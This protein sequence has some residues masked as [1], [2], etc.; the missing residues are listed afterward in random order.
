ML[1]Q[2]STITQKKLCLTLSVC[3]L[4][5]LSLPFKADANCNEPMPPIWVAEA[6]MSKLMRTIPDSKRCLYVSNSD[7]AIHLTG[8]FDT[9]TGA[10][11]AKVLEELP[12][13]RWPRDILSEKE[14]EVA[15]GIVLDELVA[16]QQM[17]N[18]I[19]G[20]CRLSP[21]QEARIRNEAAPYAIAGYINPMVVMDSSYRVVS[22][23][24]NGCERMMML[25]EY[26]HHQFASMGRTDE[27][28]IRYDLE[29]EKQSK[30]R[31]L[32]WNS[33]AANK[34]HFLW[35]AWVPETGVF[36]INIIGGSE[37]KYKQYLKPF[38]AKVEPGSSFC[39]VSAGGTTIE[40]LKTGQPVKGKK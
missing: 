20:R 29:P 12:L 10:E 23:P 5:L 7:S 22:A 35:F 17:K 1:S 19:A 28:T 9:M 39:I 4:G 31:K 18:F 37:K 11:K 32:F 26:D 40:K 6:A 8:K 13:Q 30:M 24:Y 14:I 21:E 27:R 25:T 33:V 34:G 38:L 15:T 16:R 36:E 2:L 3:M